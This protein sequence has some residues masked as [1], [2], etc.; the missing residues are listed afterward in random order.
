M[1]V[2]GKVQA[3]AKIMH[4]SFLAHDYP[5]QSRSYGHEIRDYRSPGSSERD[6]FG[7]SDHFDESYPGMNVISNGRG[8]NRNGSLDDTIMLHQLRTGGE[9]RECVCVCVRDCIVCV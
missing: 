4:P 3:S 7:S 6:D 5:G 2:R 9:E 1:G 8:H